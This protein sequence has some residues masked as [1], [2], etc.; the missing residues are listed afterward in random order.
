MIE[1]RLALLSLFGA[2]I[3]FGLMAFLA[4]IASTSIGGAQMSAIRFAIGFLP[5]LLVPAWRRKALV[6]TRTD[7]LVYR[8]VFGGFAVLCFF[9]AIEHIPVGTA[10]L[11]NYMSPVFAAL[12]ASL[13]ANEHASR[14]VLIPLA[15]ATVGVGLVV[16]SGGTPTSRAFLGFGLWEAV[17]LMSAICSGAALVAIRMARRTESSWAVFVSFSLFGFLATMPFA[18]FDW[19]WPDT[20]EWVLLAGI[21]ITSFIAQLL[22]T[23]GYRWVDNVTA[24]VIAQFAVIVA[25]VLGVT[26]LSEPFPMRAAIGTG[27]GIAGVIAVV[28]ARAPTTPDVQSPQP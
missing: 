2:S 1:R 15:V 17:G 10:T 21:G 26:V 8:G 20:R 5:A 16:S 9:L 13:F 7:L 14:R 28:A 3:F 19:K 4:K 6:W 27:L 12:F 25:T 11:L 24:G 18:M 23:H 22:M